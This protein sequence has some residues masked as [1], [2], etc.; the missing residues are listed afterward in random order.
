MT[1]QGQADGRWAYVASTSHRSVLFSHN[2]C[3]KTFAF[4]S[5]PPHPEAVSELC[6]AY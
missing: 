2:I 4:L 6:V 3:Q 1:G 5:S